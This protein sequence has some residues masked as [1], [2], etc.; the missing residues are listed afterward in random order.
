MHA[1]VYVCVCACTCELLTMFKTA[2][3]VTS[4]PALSKSRHI[5]AYRI[6]VSLLTTGF[7]PGRSNTGVRTCLL[8]PLYL[9]SSLRIFLVSFFSAIC[10]AD[11]QRTPTKA[12]L[13]A[14]QTFAHGP[15]HVRSRL[16][17]R[18]LAARQSFA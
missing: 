8:L 7:R 3:I 10:A 9:C 1:C 14:R 2:S 4:M 13:A 12:Y 5:S 15:T 6:S 11:K 18:S 17:R 16:A